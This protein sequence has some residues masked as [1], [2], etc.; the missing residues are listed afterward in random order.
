MFKHFQLILNVNFSNFYYFLFFKL[1][2]IERTTFI[3]NIILL[4]VIINNI[5]TFFKFKIYIFLMCLITEVFQFQTLAAR[6]ARASK[7]Q[8]GQPNRIRTKPLVF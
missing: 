2:K 5:D 6:A 1:L 3:N 4:N 7:S 8:V